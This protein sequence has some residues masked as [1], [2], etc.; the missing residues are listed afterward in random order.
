MK[1]QEDSTPVTGNMGWKCR[2][3]HKVGTKTNRDG[4]PNSVF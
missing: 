3:Q 1:G 2:K 4:I